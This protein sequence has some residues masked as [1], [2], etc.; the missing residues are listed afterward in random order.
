MKQFNGNINPDLL[1][2]D[3]HNELLDNISSRDSYRYNDKFEYENYYLD[4]Y[5]YDEVYLSI[6]HLIVGSFL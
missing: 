4:H 6:L 5:W 1:Y 3:Y 2:A